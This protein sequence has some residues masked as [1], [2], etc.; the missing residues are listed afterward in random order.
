MDSDFDAPEGDGDAEGGAGRERELRAGER[1]SATARRKSRSAYV[2][3][4]S[5]RRKRR[6]T[7]PGNAKPRAAAATPAAR[8]RS[9]LRSST[10]RASAAAAESRARRAEQEEKRRMKKAERDAKRPIVHVPTQEE[11]LEEA[12]ET[13]LANKES[14][15]DLLKLEEERKRVPVRKTSEQKKQVM[16]LRDRNGAA[17]IS[18]T[19]AD[20]EAR[21]V[22]FPQDK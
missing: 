11:M 10:K 5:R 19:D 20:T 8:E 17:T 15:K 21:Q 7:D 18:F 13:E 12:K 22:L 4:A 3:P 14:L 1:A 9:S 2:D 6:A 16:S